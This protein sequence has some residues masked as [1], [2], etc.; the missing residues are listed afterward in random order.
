MIPSAPLT[1]VG[2]NDQWNSGI[3]ELSR[4]SSILIGHWL[5]SY[6]YWCKKRSR[7]DFRYP[8]KKK[9]IIQISMKLNWIRKINLKQWPPENRIYQR[10]LGLTPSVKKTYFMTHCILKT[11]LQN[12]KNFDGTYLW[13]FAVSVLVKTGDSD[14]C[15]NDS[16]KTYCILFNF[17]IIVEFRQNQKGE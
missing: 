1:P 16:R 13:Y 15:I 14:L 2:V 12:Q 3:I 8:F 7:E 10:W 17:T 5:H 11:D 9:R 4:Q 6:A